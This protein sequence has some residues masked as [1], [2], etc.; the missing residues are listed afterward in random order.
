MTT[1]RAEEPPKR[2]NASVRALSPD[3]DA[4]ASEDDG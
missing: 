4:P 1:Q 3:V 2:V